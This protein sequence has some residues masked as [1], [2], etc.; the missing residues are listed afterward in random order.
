VVTF[1]MT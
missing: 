1:R